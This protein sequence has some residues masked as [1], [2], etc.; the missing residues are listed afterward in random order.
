MER[1]RVAGKFVRTSLDGDGRE[2]PRGKKDASK[3]PRAKDCGPYTRERIA[4]AL[5]EIVE[6]FVKEAKNGSIAHTKL[7]AVLSGLDKGYKEAPVRKRQRKSSALLAMEK[8]MREAK[9]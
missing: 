1:E 5:P 2:R 6:I 7:L 4:E 8:L 3:A 9:R